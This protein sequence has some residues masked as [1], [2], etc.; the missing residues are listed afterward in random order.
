MRK[1]IFWL[2]LASK[3][4]L[5]E[6]ET[7]IFSVP[8]LV[9][10][11]SDSPILRRLISM[12]EKLMKKTSKP[13]TLIL[14]LTP[15]VLVSPTKLQNLVMWI[16]SSRNKREFILPL[17]SMKQGSIRLKFQTISDSSTSIVLTQLPSDSKLSEHCSKKKVS[18][19][20]CHIVLAATHHSSRK[21]RSR[22]LSTSRES[23]QNS[24]HKMNLLIGSQ[25]I[26]SMDDSSNP[27]NLLQTGASLVRDFGE[28]RCLSGK[29]PTEVSGSSLALAKNS[30]R[31]I[32]HSG[33]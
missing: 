1:C 19:T 30:I 10:N 20:E 11:S 3:Q 32:N 15:T 2:H 31:E 12:S 7:I 26:S 14:S 27:S 23:N 33:R 22:G 9:M 5:N 29:M 8:F 25:I 28:H 13:T 24:S 17:Q 21:R 6:N 16:S 4:F 18:R